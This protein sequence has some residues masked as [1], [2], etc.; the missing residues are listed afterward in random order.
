RNDRGPLRRVA[1][2][3]VLRMACRQR[4]SLA[5]AEERGEVRPAQGKSRK[6]PIRR[7]FLP[8]RP[9]RPQRPREG[10]G[11]LL[12]RADEGPVALVPEFGERAAGG[13]GREVARVGAEAETQRITPRPGHGRLVFHE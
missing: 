11:V 2:A 5:V 6:E 1:G 7:R 8:L 4:L 3:A 13:A 12:A 10:S 9:P